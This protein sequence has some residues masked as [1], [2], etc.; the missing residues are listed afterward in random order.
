M[1]SKA[2]S[3]R[4][5][6]EDE[7]IYECMSGSKGNGKVEDSV[8]SASCRWGV[9][10]RVPNPDGKELSKWMTRKGAAGAESETLLW[11]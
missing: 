5:F 2:R 7:N 10:G 3:C 1:A 4:E 8:F 11:F 6:L 9:I